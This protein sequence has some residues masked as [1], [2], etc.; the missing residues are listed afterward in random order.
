MSMK[1]EPIRAHPGR[2]AAGAESVEYG[3]GAGA[4]PQAEVRRELLLRAPRALEVL[5]HHLKRKSLD[6]AIFVLEATGVAVRHVRHEGV[7]WARNDE[8]IPV[9][10]RVQ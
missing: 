3:P 10:S 8:A 7:G 1:R 2:T 4:F 9:K 5:D 6:A